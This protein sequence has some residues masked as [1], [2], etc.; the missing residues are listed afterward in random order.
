MNLGNFVGN[1][2]LESNNPPNATYWSHQRQSKKHISGRPK[3]RGFLVNLFWPF[4]LENKHKANVTITLYV[5]NCFL[6]LG[7]IIIPLS[8]SSLLFTLSQMKYWDGIDYSNQ[9]TTLELVVVIGLGQFPFMNFK[10]IVWF[11]ILLVNLLS[12]NHEI[13]QRIERGAWLISSR[14]CMCHHPIRCVKFTYIKVKNNPYIC[15]CVI[16]QTTLT[17]RLSFILG[18]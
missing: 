17:R 11:G 18:I 16:D 12:L 5:A 2:H 9:F 14:W 4:S 13:L 3:C 7:P 10:I 1:V 6:F 15:M 8:F